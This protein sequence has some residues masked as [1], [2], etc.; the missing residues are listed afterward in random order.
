MFQAWLTF[1]MFENA[2]RGHRGDELEA[3]RRGIAEMLSPMTQIAAEELGLPMDKVDLV[4]GDSARGP[5]AS[6]S[7]GSSPRP[8]PPTG[9][10]PSPSSG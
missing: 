1:A 6:V 3:Y 5:Y 8:S 4:L 7:A 9:C 10:Q 2:R